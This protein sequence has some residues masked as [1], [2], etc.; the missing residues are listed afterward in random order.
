MRVLID[1]SLGQPESTAQMVRVFHPVI[2][3]P[4]MMKTNCRPFQQTASESP[5][6]PHGLLLDEHL[7]NWQNLSHNRFHTRIV[8]LLQS[9]S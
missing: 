1:C 8:T 5:V 2:S 7:H 4:A 3:L 9:N 6:A